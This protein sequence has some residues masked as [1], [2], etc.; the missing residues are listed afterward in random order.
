MG[1]YSFPAREQRSRNGACFHNSKNLWLY[2]LH[3]DFL[4][5]RI[6]LAAGNI[7]KGA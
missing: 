4:A 6:K 1:V 7:V 2:W 3:V 5:D